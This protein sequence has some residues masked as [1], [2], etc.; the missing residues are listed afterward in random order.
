MEFLG[1]LSSAWSLF[2]ALMK[3]LDAFGGVL[4][5]PIPV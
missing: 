1:L 5:A 4:P 2:N 3:F